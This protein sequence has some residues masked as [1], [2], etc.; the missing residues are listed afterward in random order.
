MRK[1]DSNHDDDDHG[2]DQDPYE[3][4]QHCD[5]ERALARHLHFWQD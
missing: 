1:G 5:C 2:E 4:S 3:D